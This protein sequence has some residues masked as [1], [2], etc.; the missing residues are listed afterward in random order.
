MSV[1][2]SAGRRALSIA[3]LVVMMVPSLGRAAGPGVLYLPL[4]AGGAPPVSQV[5]LTPVASGLTG[6]TDVTHAGDGD[7]QGGDPQDGRLFIVQQGGQIRIL[8]DG[9]LL[10]APFLDISTRVAPGGERGLLGLAFH[11]DY[12]A[13]GYFYVNYTYLA[14]DG[15]LRSRVAR[16]TVSGDPDVA[17]AGSEL[18]IIEFGQPFDNHNGGALHFGPDGYLYIATGDGGGSYDPED[19]SQDTGNLLGKILRIDVD[20]VGGAD[21]GIAPGRSYGIPPGNPLADGAG[22]ACDEIWAYGLRNPWRFSFDR[23]A[24][25][26]WI[27]DVGQASREEIDFQPAGSLGGQNYGWD[28][29]E[30]TVQN[31]TGRSPAC[32][33][34]PPTAAPVHEYDHSGGRCSITGGYVHRGLGQPRLYGLYFFADYCSGELWTLRLTGGAPAV[35][36]MIVTGAALNNP[37]TFGQDASGELFVASPTAVFRISAD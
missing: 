34:N 27:A 31:P 7:P 29:W 28:C 17:N 23:L 36:E 19:N 15:G 21:C 22:G 26:L 6:I 25:D 37:R 9:A 11:P 32:A 8:K 35:T 24:G 33:A 14:M 13:N 4:A 2:R 16:F 20:E 10:T 12:A 18:A 30:G 3:L 5:R 1:Y